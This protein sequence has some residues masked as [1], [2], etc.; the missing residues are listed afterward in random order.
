MQKQNTV[1]R[2]Y[3]IVSSR[4]EL[5]FKKTKLNWTCDRWLTVPESFLKSKTVEVNIHF[6]LN[7]VAESRAG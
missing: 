3:S 7:T 1:I 2:I 4:T 5:F 6:L